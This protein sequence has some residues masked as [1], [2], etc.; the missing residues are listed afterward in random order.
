MNWTRI[1]AAVLASGLAVSMT[2]WLF[3]GDLFAPIYRAEPQIWRQ[4]SEGFREPLAITGGVALGFGTC[5]GLILVCVHLGLYSYEQT[6]AMAAAIWLI[7]PLPLVLT[8]SFFMKF[9]PLLAA[10]HAAGWL[11]KLCIAALA[12]V[13]IV[14]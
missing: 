6:L 7:A 1:A 4:K 9:H 8:N 11:V 3:M 13:W 5:A 2:D 12:V 14:G 10:S